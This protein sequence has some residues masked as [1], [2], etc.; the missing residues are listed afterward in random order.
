MP[1]RGI[2]QV[3]EALRRRVSGDANAPDD[4]QLHDAVLSYFRRVDQ[5]TESGVDRRLDHA[6]D[7]IFALAR[8]RIADPVELRAVSNLVQQWFE[9]YRAT[10]R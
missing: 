8:T 1:I 5:S 7:K 3:D 6:R 10:G 9:E 2:V 4:Q